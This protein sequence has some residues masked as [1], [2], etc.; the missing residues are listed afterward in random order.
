MAVQGRDQRNKR[1][2]RNIIYS[3]LSSHPPTR[4]LKNGTI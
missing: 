3:N 2:V 4:V 1:L